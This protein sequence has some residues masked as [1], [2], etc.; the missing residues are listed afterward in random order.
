MPQDSSGAAPTAGPD[1]HDAAAPKA[2]L[3][4]AEMDT[5]IQLHGGVLAMCT[6][7]SPHLLHRR[8]AP[9][10]HGASLFQ[11]HGH[12][13]EIEVRERAFPC[14]ASSA[15]FSHR[16]LGASLSLRTKF[17]MAKRAGTIAL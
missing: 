2:L 3:D 12:I 1:A 10:Q 16:S 17:E 14:T 11:Q 6:A 7:K 13:R 4:D 9:T 5:L 15:Q 8:I